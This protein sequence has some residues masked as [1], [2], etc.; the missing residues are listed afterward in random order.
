M[1]KALLASFLISLGV[2]V[3]LSIGYPYGP[4]FFSMGLLG[5]CVF[6]ADLFTGRAGYWWRNKKID[7]CIAL[8]WNVVWGW[9]FG[10]LM[11]LAN[12]NLVS[13]AVEKLIVDSKW[14][15]L[16]ESFACGAI[17]FFCV[18]MFNRK[19]SAGIFLGVPAFIYCGYQHSVANAIMYGVA[20]QF[21]NIPCIF[22]CAFGNFLGAIFM[23]LL[24]EE[25]NE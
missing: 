6:K 21:P 11:G 13:I 12:P 23:S 19:V 2:A 15:Y 22:I 18:D 25:E 20:Q 8:Y 4:I 17:M 16:Y 7:L 9:F 14:I 3:N 24:T 10:Y 1:S 5:V